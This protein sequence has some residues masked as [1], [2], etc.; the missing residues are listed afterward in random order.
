MRL[1]E[2]A[3][4]EAILADGGGFIAH[5]VLARAE[6]DEDVLRLGEQLCIEGVRVRHV[7]LFSSSLHMTKLLTLVVERN[8]QFEVDHSAMEVIV[9]PMLRRS[10]RAK[11]SFFFVKAVRELLLT[12]LM[13]YIKCSM[14]G[15]ANEMIKRL[16][17][18]EDSPRL[19]RDVLNS[20]L[21]R[22][23]S[24]D[25]AAD[26][27]VGL[28]GIVDLDCEHILLLYTLTDE[29]SAKRYL[30]TWRIERAEKTLAL[31]SYLK[32]SPK[33]HI[34]ADFA[35]FCESLVAREAQ[36]RGGEYLRS[37]VILKSHFL[38]TS[39][40]LPQLLKTFLVILAEDRDVMN[41]GPWY[42]LFGAVMDGTQKAVVSQKEWDI[43]E[44]WKS[45][46]K[47]V[48]STLGVGEI[49]KKN[50]VMTVMV[51]FL[52]S[53]AVDSSRI[54]FTAATEQLW[55]TWNPSSSWEVA[56]SFLE[57]ITASVESFSCD[58]EDVNHKRRLRNL[59]ESAL[60]STH[61]YLRSSAFKLLGALCVANLDEDDDFIANAVIATLTE[62]TEE[63]VRREAARFFL[64]CY[65]GR[66]GR[67]RP[68]TELV[69]IM[70]GT[71]CDLDWEV[72]ET[73]LEYW[74]TV[75]ER[76]GGEENFPRH[77]EESWCATA[78]ARAMAEKEVRFRGKLSLILNKIRPRIGEGEHD[79]RDEKNNSASSLDSSK[80]SFD[81]FKVMLGKY[82]IVDPEKAL[83]EYCEVHQGLWSVVADIVQSVEGSNKLDGI[84]CF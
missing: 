33:S 72:R 61:F 79:K 77:L 56:D 6:V 84:D 44:T 21:R 65:S 15:R 50:R 43:E 82:E 58:Q 39:Q 73:A 81:A 37:I 30:K 36:E 34:V 8:P 71:V 35:I 47:L 14:I 55:P 31:C 75:V 57:V 76:E 38:V 26:G 19:P 46:T 49:T 80:V 67:P 12:L 22:L 23:I 10:D 48:A 4:F 16:F 7:D 78:L 9:L 24:E 27:L 40:R 51:Q 1:G 17:E 53:V 2:E 5:L 74:A 59:A 62:D 18:A 28:D 3:T 83:D 45:L 69:K 54:T 32:R 63:I 11:W 29:T 66:P 42:N 20:L 41:D 13:A 70:C 52:R 64:R 68:P 60:Q 25:T